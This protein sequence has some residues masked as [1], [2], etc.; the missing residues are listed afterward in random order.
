MMAKYH[1]VIILFHD[2]FCENL[3]AFGMVWSIV[4]CYRGGLLR[5]IGGWKLW[6]QMAEARALR[7]QSEAKCSSESEKFAV[8][9]DYAFRAC[10]GT[11]QLQLGVT[12]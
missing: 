6:Q 10:E 1:N 2:Y 4:C 12:A 8:S 3:S 5:R 9:G 11:R 7:N